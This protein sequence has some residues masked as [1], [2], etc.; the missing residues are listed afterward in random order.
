[1]PALQ[2][3]QRRGAPTTRP[4]SSTSR[5]AN[6]QI[7]PLILTSPAGAIVDEEVFSADAVTP[8]EDIVDGQRLRRP[9]HRSPATTST[10]WS[11]SSRTRSTRACSAPGEHD[12]VDP[13]LLRRLVEP[14]AR[15]PGGQHRRRRTAA[16]RRPTSRTSSGNDK[17]TVIDGPGGE[18]RYIVFNFNTQPYGATTPRP[19]RPRRWPCARP[20]PTSSTATRSRT[21]VYKGTY[22]RCTP[23]SRR[24]SPAP[25]RCSRTCTAT[26]TAD[27]M[28]PR[29]RPRPRGRRRHDPGRAQPAVQ[30]GPLRSVL[31]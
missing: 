19:T 6:D 18:I 30:P 4:W 13:E 11:S 23:S 28:R 27:R 5:A 21:Q 10:T 1:M 17:V 31:G 16:S 7:F 25:P 15:R 26:A 20:S 12:G 8:D 2:P 9:V 29:P 14:E 3:R 22:R 24:A